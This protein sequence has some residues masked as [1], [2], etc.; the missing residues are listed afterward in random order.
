MV[1]VQL[2]TTDGRTV[3]LSRY[4]EPEV[5]QAVLLQRLKISLPAQSPPRILVPNRALDIFALSSDPPN[6]CYSRCW[7]QW[8]QGSRWQ[9]P[10]LVTC[11]VKNAGDRE[12]ALPAQKERMR[13]LQRCCAR[14]CRLQSRRLR[15]RL[16]MRTASR[17]YATTISGEM[18]RMYGNLLGMPFAMPPRSKPAPSSR[19]DPQVAAQVERLRRLLKKRVMLRSSP[20]SG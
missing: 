17:R 6:K 18:F 8:R 4:T 9:P 20:S 19:C 1:D 11:Q 3:I 10:S 12:L 14:C 7:R 16:G 15:R 2:P 5:D 13:R